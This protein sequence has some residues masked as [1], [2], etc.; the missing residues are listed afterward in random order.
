MFFLSV[1]L[2]LDSGFSGLLVLSFLRDCFCCFSSA[3]VAFL[4]DL[5]PYL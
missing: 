5:N 3:L 2:S 4:G 1:G